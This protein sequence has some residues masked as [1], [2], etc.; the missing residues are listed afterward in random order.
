MQVQKQQLHLAFAREL[1]VA[2]VESKGSRHVVASLGVA[3]LRCLVGGGQDLSEEAEI[4]EE[5]IARIG[6]LKPAL[7]EE[8]KAG[9]EDRDPKNSGTTKAFRNVAMHADMGCGAEGLPKSGQ[10]AKRMQRGGVQQG[11]LRQLEQTL[12]ETTELLAQSEQ[13]NK[14][15]EIELKQYK[16]KMQ[17]CS[18]HTLLVDNALHSMLMGIELGHDTTLDAQVLNFRLRGFETW[19]SGHRAQPGHSS[20][21]QFMEVMIM[22]RSE[23]NVPVVD[24]EWVLAAASTTMIVSPAPSSATAKRQD[25]LEA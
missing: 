16:E 18:L 4:D 15:M 7:K 10:Q 14:E 23:K 9:A 6:L 12:S 20:S 24:W 13:K 8:V 22:G 19:R 3:L 25:E 5:V 1:V 2:A 17:D 21:Q 11:R